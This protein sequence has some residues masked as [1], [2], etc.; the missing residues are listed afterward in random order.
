VPDKPKLTAELAEA[1]AAFIDDLA[2]MTQSKGAHEGHTLK[3]VGRC[4]YCSC[5]ER[6]QG[7][8]PGGKRGG[9]A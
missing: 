8:L 2:D 3:Q 7:R 6:Y 5:G 4:V 9:H 1:V